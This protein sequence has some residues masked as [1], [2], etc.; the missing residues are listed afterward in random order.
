MWKFLVSG[1]KKLVTKGMPWLFRGIKKVAPKALSKWKAFAGK[2]PAL[3]SILE[4]LVIDNTVGDAI[5]WIVDTL[6]NK[7]VDKATANEF[8]DLVQ[9]TTNTMSSTIDVSWADALLS[10]EDSGKGKPGGKRS[11][12]PYLWAN[13]SSKASI[14]TEKESGI[15]ENNRFNRC[16]VHNLMHLLKVTSSITVPGADKFNFEVGMQSYIKDAYYAFM[17]RLPG[18][19]VSETEA[20]KVVDAI[21]TAVYTSFTTMSKFKALLRYEDAKRLTVNGDTTPCCGMLGSIRPCTQSGNTYYLPGMVPMKDQEGDGQNIKID[22]NDIHDYFAT[23]LHEPDNLYYGVTISNK[24]WSELVADIKKYTYV[25]KT[26]Y[27]FIDYLFRGI[28]ADKGSE[29]IQECYVFHPA[30][31][32]RTGRGWYDAVNITVLQDLYND[33]NRIKSAIRFHPSIIPILTYMDLGQKSNYGQSADSWY[34]LEFK[35][36]FDNNHLE[37][38]D[39]DKTF[40][41][42]IANATVNFACY[43]NYTPGGDRKMTTLNCKSPIIDSNKIYMYDAL[44]V[45]FGMNV[46]KDEPNTVTVL[47]GEVASRTKFAGKASLGYLSVGFYIQG[48]DLNKS[49]W[50]FTMPGCGFPEWVGKDINNR[51]PTSVSLQPRDAFMRVTQYYGDNKLCMSA[52]K[53]LQFNTEL[54]AQAEMD[55]KKKTQAG[56]QEVDVYELPAIMSYQYNHLLFNLTMLKDY[57]RR[58]NAIEVKYTLEA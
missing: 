31:G 10:A 46:Y 55:I 14:L 51:L 21:E 53:T 34:Q 40:Y 27:D 41:E 12:H 30:W 20:N 38:L 49:G 44:D 11:N 28:F 47:S 15:F 4:Y 5:D 6:T 52:I 33:I 54:K 36:N 57:I 37:V 50:Q 22:V 58:L 1:A 48:T 26:A 18:A 3:S 29:D 16:R 2:H 8:K 7:G 9:E 39:T 35:R 13:D 23:P 25:S 24:A 17:A 42:A 19:T 45:Q 32:T 56:Y 43:T